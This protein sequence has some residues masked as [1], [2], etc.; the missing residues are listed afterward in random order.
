MAKTENQIITDI[1]A[2]KV[3]PVYLFTGEENYYIDLLSDY[4]EAHAVPEDSRP[5]D[6]TVLYGRDTDM[7]SVIGAAQQMPLTGPRRL[8]LVKEAQD[9]GGV[10]QRAKAQWEQL[11]PYLQHPNLATMLVFCYRHK[12]FDKRS[13]AYKAIDAAGVVFDHKRLYDRDVPPAILQMVSA[14]G[15]RISEKAA[16]LLAACIGPDLSKIGNELGKLY[17]TLPAGGTITEQLIE[18]N[19]GI[20]KDYNVFELQSAIGRGDVALCSRIVAHFAANPKDNPIQLVLAS[21]YGYFVKVMIY[22]QCPDRSSA[23]LA[24]AVG[25]SPYF[26]RDYDTAARRYPLAKLASCIDYLYDADLRSKG[27]RN[28]GSVSSGELLKELIFK[29]TH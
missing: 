12:A 6:Q 11:I 19:V 7:L 18:T 28:S 27:I 17:I 3:A 21:L 15:Y 22:A 2:G 1:Q 5:F 23:A 16:L 24:K 26:L 29:I 8:V 4:V 25:V 13:K 14:A 20:S 9:I 10:P